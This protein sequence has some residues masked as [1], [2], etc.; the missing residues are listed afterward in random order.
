MGQEEVGEILNSTQTQF[1]GPAE[2]P[3]AHHQT[4]PLESGGEGSIH[5][6]SQVVEAP[7]GRKI[8]KHLVPRKGWLFLGHGNMV[9]SLGYRAVGA[10][11]CEVESSGIIVIRN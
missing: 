5:P 1:P 6:A 3:W 9:C 4:P 2:S 8:R 10:R 7:A 11:T